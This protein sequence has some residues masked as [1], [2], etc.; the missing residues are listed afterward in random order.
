LELLLVGTQK[1]ERLIGADEERVLPTVLDAIEV[2]A[3]ISRPLV[4]LPPL[5]G[6]GNTAQAARVAPIP[7]LLDFGVTQ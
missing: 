2:E 3:P 5:G 7:S 1:C 4:M 6:A